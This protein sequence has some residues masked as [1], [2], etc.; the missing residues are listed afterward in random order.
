MKDD[1]VGNGESANAERRFHG[2]AL[3]RSPQGLH[4]R[5]VSHP[6]G[7]NF[8]PSSQGVLS[9]SAIRVTMYFVVLPADYVAPAPKQEYHGM[10][11][12]SAAPLCARRVHKSVTLTRIHSSARKRQQKTNTFRSSRTCHADATRSHYY[13]TSV[14]CCPRTANLKVTN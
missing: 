3:M 11:V 14:H 4:S 6:Y 5:C 9:C 12:T 7:R 13:H 2:K 1:F 8:R 10:H